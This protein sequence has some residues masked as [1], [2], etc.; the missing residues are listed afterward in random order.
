MSMGEWVAGRQFLDILEQEL[1]HK[2]LLVP[3][4][5]EKT[6]SEMSLAE[7]HLAGQL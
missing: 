7:D 1:G 6:D 2:L 5:D 3:F 4:A